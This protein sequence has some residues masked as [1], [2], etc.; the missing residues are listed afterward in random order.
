MSPS[1]RFGP[2]LLAE[3]IELGRAVPRPAGLQNR[4]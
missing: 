1:E 2:L 3:D 4:T